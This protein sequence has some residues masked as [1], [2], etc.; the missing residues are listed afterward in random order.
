MNTES[1]LGGTQASS[2][3]GGE[4][5]ETLNRADNAGTARYSGG[6]EPRARLRAFQRR[7]TPFSY[8]HTSPIPLKLFQ[9]FMSI[10]LF[11]IGYL[12]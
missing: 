3:Y 5:F 8:Q 1:I 10:V 11:K 12:L 2:V 6:R 9:I 4:S 7:R